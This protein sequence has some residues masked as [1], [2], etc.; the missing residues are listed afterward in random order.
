MAPEKGNS[1][2]KH[3]ALASGISS[4]LLLILAGATAVLA[5]RVPSLIFG[6]LLVP[7]FICLMVSIHFYSD[8]STRLFSMLGIVFSSMYGILISFNYFLQLALMDKN[9][10][11]L[12]LF[13]MTNPDTIM[14]VIEVLGYFFMGLS[15]LAIMP[16]FKTSLLERLIKALLGLNGLFGI[17]GLIGYV[18]RWDMSILYGGLMLWNIIMPVASALIV[19]FF[20][21][22]EP[23]NDL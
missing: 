2:I 12:D 11:G 22:N 10:P 17:G 20:R 4:T 21:T 18:L 19:V 14:W 15:T 23:S 13:L 16:V 1:G 5:I 9:I 6:F 7:C 8:K 3:F